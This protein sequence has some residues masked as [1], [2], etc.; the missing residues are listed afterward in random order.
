M[1]G[2]GREP[3]GGVR[4]NSESMTIKPGYQP[5]VILGTEPRVVVPVARSLSRHGVPVTVVG[6]SGEGRPLRSRA[7]Q[8]YANCGSCKNN[9]DAFVEEL[10]HLIE[11]R[12]CS[13]LIPSNDTA[14]SLIA[15]HYQRLTG[16]VHVASSLPAVVRQVLDKDLTL[17]IASKCGI[18]IPASYKIDHRVQLESFRSQLQ[19]PVVAKPR[20]KT[21]IEKSPFKVRYFQSYDELASLFE[22]RGK[23]VVPVVLQEYCPGVGVGVAAL[24]R[25]GEPLVLFQHRRLAE[26]PYT[27]GVAVRAV[28]EELHHDLAEQAVS[29]LRALEWEG[30]AMVEFRKDLQS[31]RTVLIEVNGRYWG[32]ISL[33]VQAG[34]DFPWYEW[35]LAHHQIPSPPVQYRVGV[36]WHWLS[37]DV[38]RLQGVLF[39]TCPGHL[40]R[41]FRWKEVREFLLASRL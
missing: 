16:L 21:D 28:S 2:T 13:M 36:K 30:I 33:A 19:F 31:S 17:Q 5:T 24:M 27:G 1:D 15:D 18:A 10:S 34:V 25:K 8:S 35:Q 12:H 39:D 11:Q 26:L 14:L 32:T 20:S 4:F 7:I 41:P 23:C 38:T 6:L 37:G 9:P 22:P 40:S 29:L 3:N